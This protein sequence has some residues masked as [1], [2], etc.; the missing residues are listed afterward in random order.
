M[1]ARFL[2]L[3]AVTA[4]LF[5]CQ[6]PSYLGNE[7]SPYYLVPAGSRLT[8]ER[9]LPIPAEQLAAYIQNGRVLSNG[10]VQHLYPFCKFE[11]WRLAPNPRTVPPDDIAITRTVQE[12]SPGAVTLASP[13]L[14]ARSFGLRVDSVGGA[15]GPSIH[16]FSTR[17]DLRSD[18]HPDVFRL[19][20]AQWGY[21]GIDRHV[22][23]SEIRRT[24]AGV[25]TLRLPN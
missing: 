20:C 15:A 16:S 4:A 13:I 19:T 7:N 24:L 6:T 10:E 5:G 23:I 3:A 25:F 14:L 11:L 8:L 17:M 21:P 9:D 22:T 2:C 12:M 1:F 18:K